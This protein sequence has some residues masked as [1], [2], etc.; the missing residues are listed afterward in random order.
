MKRKGFTLIELLGVMTLLAI[1]F[2][3]VYPNI[4]Q[5]LDKGKESE[6]VEY[7]SSVF[8]AAEAYVNS[9]T[10][11]SNQL[12]NEGDSISISYSVLLENG[13]L[14]SKLTDPRT[15]Q[16]VISLATNKVK[17]TVAKDKTF[18]YSIES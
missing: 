12:T 18:T 13:F 17:V 11:L 6:Y 7:E 1:I 14:N 9:N 4:I 16:T 3:F 5:M 10:T 2:A 8:L 15:G